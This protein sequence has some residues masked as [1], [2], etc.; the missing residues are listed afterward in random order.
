M[1][2]LKYRCKSNTFIDKMCSFKYILSINKVKL[3]HNQRLKNILSCRIKTG[4]ITFV[5]N[6][7][8]ISF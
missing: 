1:I 5:I 3:F 8:E 4:G 6:V 2:P 7:F